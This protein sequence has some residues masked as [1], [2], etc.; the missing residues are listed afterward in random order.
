MPP[1]VEQALTGIP[2][3]SEL[4]GSG[5]LARV[6]VARKENHDVLKVAA[7]LGLEFGHG[8]PRRRRN[9]FGD[10]NST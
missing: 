8:L 10:R 4:E 6:V 7:E 9:T 3:N 1:A 5:K 2:A